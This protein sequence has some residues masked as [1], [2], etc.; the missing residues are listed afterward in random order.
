MTARKL[1]VI[2]LILVVLSTMTLSAQQNNKEDFFSF[3]YTFAHNKEF[4]IQRVKFPVLYTSW[5]YDKNKKVTSVIEKSDYVT[6]EFYFKNLSDDGLFISFFDNFRP[7]F[8]DSG[9]MVLRWWGM[10][11]M[12]L[13]YYFKKIE[14]KWYLV[15][16]SSSD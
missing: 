14:R 9:K 2:Q 3:I 13:R 11:D 8:R 7:K 15:R 16:I 12:D 5:D 1:L 6:T 4:Q 10:S